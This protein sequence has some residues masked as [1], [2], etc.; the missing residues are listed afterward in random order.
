MDIF[1]F[2]FGFDFFEEFCDE[3]DVEEFFAPEGDGEFFGG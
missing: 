2:D 1:V 3:V